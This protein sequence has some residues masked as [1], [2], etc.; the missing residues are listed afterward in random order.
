MY[1]N[2]DFIHRYVYLIKLLILPEFFK[3]NCNLTKRFQSDLLNNRSFKIVFLISRVGNHSS[4]SLKRKILETN[5][6]K[7]SHELYLRKFKEEMATFIVVPELT[8]QIKE[9]TPARLF[10]KFHSTLFKEFDLDLFMFTIRLSQVNLTDNK[11]LINP[12]YLYRRL[13]ILYKIRKHGLLEV[14]RNNLCFPRNFYIFTVCVKE[15]KTFAW[16]LLIIRILKPEILRNTSTTYIEDKKTILTKKSDLSYHFNFILNNLGY[17][18]RFI[19]K[20]TTNSESIH[21]EAIFFHKQKLRGAVDKLKGANQETL[22][23]VLNKIIFDWS[24][25]TRI[26]VVCFQ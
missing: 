7:V 16:N 19:L 21:R 9:E 8:D 22:I 1:I 11:F 2:W 4:I 6:S 24:I 14:H 18:S 3:I 13:S 23:L 20:N 26:R 12:R 10:G 5:F 17:R 25:S 15:I